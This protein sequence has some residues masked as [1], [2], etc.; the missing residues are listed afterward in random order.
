[1]NRTTCG[2]CPRNSPDGRTTIP[3]PVRSN[4]LNTPVPAQSPCAGARGAGPVTPHYFQDE[5]QN[6]VDWLNY[7]ETTYPG[8]RENALLL[9]GVTPATATLRV[10]QLTHP[11]FT[12][13]R[14][15]DPRYWMPPSSSTT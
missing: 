12:G 4:F 2:L 11:L 14:V 5:V 3:Q 7:L 15:L 10:L 1:M 13:A 8:E 6:A 9:V